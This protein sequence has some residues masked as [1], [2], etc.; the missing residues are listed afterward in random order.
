MEDMVY[1]GTTLE[2]SGKGKFKATSGMPGFQLPQHQCRPEEGPVP[3]GLYYIPL[4]KGGAA[5]DDGAGI[6]R[7]QPAWQV[8]TIPRGAEA[9][10][11]EPYWANWGH[12][13]VRFEPSNAATRGKCTPKRSGFYLHDSTKGYSHGC[14]EVETTFFNALR[15]SMRQGTKKL[16]LRIRYKPGPTNGGT[17]K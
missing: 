9:G 16:T 5:K 4:I 7:L 14:I 13:R 1:D 15:T 3:E 10:A 2:W 17:K 6:C 8:Q 12:N 11:C